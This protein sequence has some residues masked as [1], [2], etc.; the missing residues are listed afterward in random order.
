MEP[1]LLGLGLSL[2]LGGL[3]PM[4]TGLA[5]AAAVVLAVMYYD[6]RNRRSTDDL[7]DGLKQADADHRQELADVG[8]LA[9]ELRVL[10]AVP[11]VD[12]LDDLSRGNTRAAIAELAKLFR[13]A[14]NG[15]GDLAALL[16]DPILQQRLPVWLED[17]NR[18]EW[19][20]DRLRKAKLAEQDDRRKEEALNVQTG[21]VMAADHNVGAADSPGHR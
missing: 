14:G 18:R 12:P 17:P 2:S 7:V 3:W 6:A 10:G 8:K 15:S 1:Y 21:R 16:A 19:L 9:T 4:L 11:L 20:H 13:R 5:V